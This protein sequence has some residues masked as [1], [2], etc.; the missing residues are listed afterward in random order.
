MTKCFV[1]LRVSG[2]S[3]VRGDGFTRQL[4]AIRQYCEKNDLKI[5]RIFKERGVSGTKEL[6]NRPAL[7]TLFLALEENGVRTV[8][9]ERLDRVARDLMIQETIIQDM[10]KKGYTLLSVY[11]PDLCSEEPSRILIRQIFGAL[12]QWERT[13]IVLKLKGARERIKEE[14]RKPGQKN[15]SP[16][17]LINTNAEGR[18]PYGQK[19]G[20]AGVLDR[21]KQLRAEGTYYKEIASILTNEG[22]LSRMGKPWSASTIQEIL[23][24]KPA[25]PAA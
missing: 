13:M 8:I 7:S 20:E 6:E 24:R 5:V 12:A 21:M 17:P 2:K 18:K 11:E 22:I 1:Y 19:P 23:T 3:Q 15:Y 9:V 25:S 10:Q 14:G 4:K 16:D